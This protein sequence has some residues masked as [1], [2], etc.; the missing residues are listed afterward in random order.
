LISNTYA[1]LTTWFINSAHVR[2]L[3]LT[4]DVLLAIFWLTGVALLAQVRF[5]PEPHSPHR[6]QDI[7]LSGFALL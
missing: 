1:I 4:L 3:I 2:W 7:P 5:P 6:R